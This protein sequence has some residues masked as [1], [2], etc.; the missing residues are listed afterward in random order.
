MPTLTATTALPYPGYPERAAAGLRAKLRDQIP[1]G[2]IPDWA[3]LHV[4]APVAV[5]GPDGRC[6]WKWT[7]TVCTRP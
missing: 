2:H 5:R 4:D 3:T 7:A 6:W 1:T